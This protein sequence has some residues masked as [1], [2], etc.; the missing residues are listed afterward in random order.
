MEELL[1]LTPHIEK[2]NTAMRQ[3]ISPQMRLSA[4]FRYLATG[5]SFQ[6]LMFSIRIVSN[7]LSQIIPETL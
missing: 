1:C 5:N 7:T 6:D 4:T 3:A 2:K